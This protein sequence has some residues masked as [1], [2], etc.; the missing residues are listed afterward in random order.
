MTAANHTKHYK[1]SQYTENDHPTYTGDYNGDMSNVAHDNTLTGDG[2]GET[3]LGV[4]AGTAINPIGKRW[5]DIDFNDFYVNGLYTFNGGSTNSPER[6][7]P[8]V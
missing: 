3:P 8:V 1:L 5:N 4:A 7:G 6:S 2:T